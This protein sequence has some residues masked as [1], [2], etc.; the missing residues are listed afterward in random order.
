MAVDSSPAAIREL[1]ARSA[2]LTIDAAVAD[3]EHGAFEIPPDSY[4]LICD[5]F[6]LQRNLFP[7]IR[8]GVRLGGTFVAAIHLVNDSPGLRPRNPAFL[9]KAGELRAEF[10]GWKILYYSEGPEPD[11][12]VRPA[13]W[14]VAR[15][16]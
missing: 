6:Y 3:L 11:R 8:A 9:L 2:G 5:F 15:R 13:A 1:R 10:A 16:A 12:R 14:I 4:D 7:R